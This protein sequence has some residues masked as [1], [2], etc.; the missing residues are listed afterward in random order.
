MYILKELDD[1][2]TT[3]EEPRVYMVREMIPWANVDLSSLHVSFEAVLKIIDIKIDTLTHK[4]DTYNSRLIHVNTKLLQLKMGKKYC[5]RVRG[6]NWRNVGGEELY[7]F[8][9][10]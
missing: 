6:N 10:I 4:P 9:N 1:P 5:V 2:F 8:A 3:K 7:R